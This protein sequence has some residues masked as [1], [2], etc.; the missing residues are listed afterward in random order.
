MS[1]EPEDIIPLP[2]DLTYEELTASQKERWLDYDT[3]FGALQRCDDSVVPWSSIL[4]WREYIL[5]QQKLDPSSA[6]LP[7][8]PPLPPCFP[9]DPSLNDKIALWLGNITHLKIDAIVNAANT[10]LLGG[11]GVDGAIHR[12]AGPALRE[13]CLLLQRPGVT[14]RAKITRA[15]ALPAG[16]VLHAVGPIGEHPVPLVSCYDACLRLALRHGLRTVAFCGISTGV[17]GYPAHH[18]AREVL[19]FVRGWLQ[20][21]SN[22]QAIDR[23]VF[24]QF[25]QRE[26]DIYL[27]VISQFF[28]WSLQ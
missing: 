16:H 19:R 8:F 13:E 14:G 22:A 17:Y 1:A 18:A 23:I 10:G 26:M 11:G 20:R 5:Y 9:V 28:P 3:N 15:Y 25:S 24:V 4:S 12:A 2:E 7:P 6:T 27:S 21:P